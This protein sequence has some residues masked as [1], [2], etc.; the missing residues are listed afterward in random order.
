MS[1]PPTRLT[2]IIYNTR[3]GGEPYAGKLSRTVRRA[4]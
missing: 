1:A 2:G 3:D 4:G